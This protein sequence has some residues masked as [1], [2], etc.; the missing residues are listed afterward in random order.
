MLS[1][2]LGVLIL[3]PFVRGETPSDYPISPVPLTSKQIKDSFW[4]PRLDIN[5]TISIPHNFHQCE[6][7]GRIDSFTWAAQ[8]MENRQGGVY[9]DSDVYKVIE[10]ASYCLVDYPDSELTNYLDNLIKVIASAQEDDGYLHTF[11]IINPKH[12]FNGDSRFSH[13]ISHELFNAGHLYE[14]SVAHYQATRRR[15]LLDIALKNAD[16]VCHVFGDGKTNKSDHP[17]IELA[18]VKLYHITGRE[19]YLNLAK[20]LCDFRLASYEYPK[21]PQEYEAAGHAVASTYVYCGM[22]DLI[23]LQRAPEYRRIIDSI[24]EG[25]V[26]KKLYLNGGIGNSDEHF[27]THYVLANSHLDH[28]PGAGQPP[29]IKTCAAIAFSLWNHRLFQLYGDAKYI[30]V[31]ERTLYNVFSSSVSLAGDTFF[32]ANAQLHDGKRFCN[33]VYK[34]RVPFFRRGWKL[35]PHQHRTFLSADSFYDLC[36]KG[37]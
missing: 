37:G 1:A 8:K 12:K 3:A 11:R 17:E 32:Y 16:L 6:L 19:K 21:D 5:R 34:E 27:G 26:S 2:S 13:P 7:T 22:T 35:L 10:G 4:K 30:D 36:S 20:R 9:F 31:L 23:A 15:G 33:A 28:T 18:L 14:A 25:V 24:W 29:E